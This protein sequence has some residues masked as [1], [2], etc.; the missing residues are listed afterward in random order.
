MPTLARAVVLLG[1][2]G[3]CVDDDPARCAEWERAGECEEN[4]GYML[5]ACAQSCAR[6]HRASSV[7]WW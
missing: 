1:L 2:V 6:A 4:P 3:A 7:G 5:A